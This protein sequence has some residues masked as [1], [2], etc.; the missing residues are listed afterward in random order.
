MQLLNVG[1]IVLSALHKTPQLHRA[2]ESSRI[3]SGGTRI[4]GGRGYSDISV[5][6]NAQSGGRTG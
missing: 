6:I 1:G 2:S 5:G 4:G 3:K